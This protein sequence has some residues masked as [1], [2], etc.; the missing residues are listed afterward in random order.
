[1]YYR[2]LLT[3]VNI[4][5]IQL[6]YVDII[7]IH[8]GI[9]YIPTFFF[10]YIYYNTFKCTWLN[11]KK[12]FDGGKY[13]RVLLSAVGCTTRFLSAHII[14][15][16]LYIIYYIR[17]ITIITRHTKFSQWRGILL[18]HMEWKDYS[19]GFWHLSSKNTYFV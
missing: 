15:K 19:M 3:S 14:G 7:G 16:Y 5:I 1:M 9:W 18:V 10:F 6:M 2:F 8:I 12:R 13:Q 17:R 4:T 11:D